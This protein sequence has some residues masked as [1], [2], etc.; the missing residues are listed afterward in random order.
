MIE[1]SELRLGFVFMAGVMTFFAPCAYPMLPGYVAYFLG[2]DGAASGRATLWRAAK[3]SLVASSGMFVVYLGIVGVAVSVGAQY[4]QRLVL[5]GAGTGLLLIALG[6]VMLGG[7][8]HLSRLTISLPERR[9]SYRGY[10]TFGAVYAVAAAG[11]TAPLFV[12]V[13]VSSFTTGTTAALVT[14]G[15]YAGGMATMF[16]LVTMATAV[17]REALL[18]VIVPRGPW[19]ERAAGVL[20]IVAGIVQLYLFLV[21]YGGLAQL[22]LA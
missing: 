4:L 7:F 14:F 3:V 9:R 11:C 12:A 21:P 15:A 1:L 6:V 19:L 22:G 20:L 5:L 8:A 10:L 13:V 2:D 18:E 17:G 16:V